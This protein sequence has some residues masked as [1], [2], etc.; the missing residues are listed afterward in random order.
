[1]ASSIQTKDLS[2]I[3]SAAQTWF[4]RCLVGD[5]SIFTDELLWTSSLVDE[6]FDAF[7]NHPDYSDSDFMTK[8]MGQMRRASPSAQKL[9][10]EMLWALLLFPS[11]MKPSTKRWQIQEVWSISSPRLPDNQQLLSDSVLAGVGSGGPGFNNYRP[12]EMEYLIAIAR[13]LKAREQT[14]RRRILQS[15]DDFINWIDLVP[16]QGLRQYRH[17][18]RYFAFPTEVERISSNNDRVKILEAFEVA[19]ASETRSW[20]DQDL[21]KALKT[22]RTKLERM[23]PSDL[24]DFYEA[25]LRSKWAAERKIRTE[26]GEIRIAVPDDDN[27]D[28]IDFDQPEQLD[29]SVVQ[30]R[31]SIQIQAKLAEIGAAM[32]FKIWI[33]RSDRVAVGRLIVEEARA[34]LLDDLPLNYESNTLDTIEHID[35][36]W[37]KKRS[38]ARAFEVEHTTAVYSGLLRMADLLALQPNM[39]IRLHI[40]APDERRSKV[41]REVQRPVFSVLD[42]GPLSESCTFLAYESIEQISGLP[43]LKHMTDKIISDYEE[44]AEP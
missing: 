23:Y 34:Y 25:P 2:P 42:R 6:V 41:F 11:N 22:L 21:D 38:I 13:D 30:S 10:A 24:L 27:D 28:Q 33:P 31:H 35:V 26:K 36:L 8:L 12:V 4:E 5:G 40:V 39:D 18:L 14:E 43:H 44:F 16:R 32:G 9:M 3:L 19:A 20:S 1:M 37:I 17:M 15:Y 29:S 7:V